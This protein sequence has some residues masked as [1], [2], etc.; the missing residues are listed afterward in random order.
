M[1]DIGHRVRDRQ[2]TYFRSE[3]YHQSMMHEKEKRTTADE[4]IDIYLTPISKIVATGHVRR[5]KLANPN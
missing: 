5:D 2:V 3:K 1:S 4:I